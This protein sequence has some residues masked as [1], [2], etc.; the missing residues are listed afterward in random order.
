MQDSSPHAPEIAA[1][2]R[3]VDSLANWMDAGYRVPVLGIRFGWDSIIGL[4]P[5]VGDLVAALPSLWI[6]AEAHRMGARR[7]TLLRMALNTGADVM[8]GSVPIV[9]DMADVALKANRR[10]A[11]LLRRD[12]ADGQRAPRTRAPLR[13][14][15]WELE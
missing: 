14:S 12:M 9:G 6:L 15:A 4:V 3:R 10:N 2:L 7:G 11:A 5:V 1:R 13:H 8:L